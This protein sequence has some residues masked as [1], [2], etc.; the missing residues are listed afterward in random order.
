M[1]YLLSSIKVSRENLNYAIIFV[2]S[3]IAIALDLGL[4]LFR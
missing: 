3:F 1:L 2:F 4:T